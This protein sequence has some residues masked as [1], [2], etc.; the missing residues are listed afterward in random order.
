MS[1][2]LGEHSKGRV[3]AVRNSGVS[4]QRQWG[5]TKQKK[6]G[7]EGFANG[8]ICSR[9]GVIVVGSQRTA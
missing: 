8:V 2:E 5:K 7:N 9:N 1:L 4:G 3:G 6:R